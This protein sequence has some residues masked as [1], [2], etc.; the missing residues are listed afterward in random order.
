MLTIDNANF[1]T[2]TWGGNWNVTK[3]ANQGHL[4]FT[5]ANGDFAG[6]NYEND[7]HN[8]IDWTG[9]AP[10]LTI[11]NAVWSDTNPYVCDM[12]NV[13]V[14]VKNIGTTDAID[15]FWVD[16]YYNLP[17]PPILYQLG[18][19]FEGIP[20]LPAGDSVIVNFY[21][22]WDSVPGIWSS[23]VQ[24]DTD[25][26]ITEL[27][28]GNNIW[29][30]DTIT[31][32][33]LPT[34]DDLTIQYN[35][36]TGE[37]ELNWTYSASADSFY[38]YRDTDPYFTPAYGTPYAS[39]NGANTIWSEPASGTKYFYIVTAVKSCPSPLPVIMKNKEVRRVSKR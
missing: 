30:P 19:Q 8:R 26:D 4:S 7:P 38:I 27:N 33:G 22:I 28:E 1:P 5:D 3:S 25:D 34:I 14:T 36:G 6:P 37:I 15:G 18:N 29:G 23:Y 2:N 9:F 21:T 16:L 10:D 31:W 12:I 17:S 35:T 20:G 11:T 32:N 24:V 13:E 39:V